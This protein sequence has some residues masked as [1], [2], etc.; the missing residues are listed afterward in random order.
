MNKAVMTLA[1]ILLAVS[2]AAAR[3]QLNEEHIAAPAIS[4]EVWIN[5]PPL[6]LDS[7]RDKVI[8]VDFWDYTCVGC[9]RMLPYLR[10][11][12]RLYGPLGL[13]AIGVQTPE[14]AF[15]K[16]PDLVAQAVKRMGISF[17]VAVDSD[18]RIWKAF[19]NDAMPCEYLIDK[20]GK[21]EYSLCGEED[22]AEF[23]RLIQQLLRQ[24]NPKLDF[25][26]ARFNPRPDPPKT[27]AG[28]VNPTPETYLGYLRADALANTEGYQPLVAASYQPLARLPFDQFD[29]SG[30]WTAMAENVSPAATT[31]GS[32]DSLRFNYRAKSVYLVAGAD[33]D[34]AASVVVTQDGKS[35]VAGSRG[36]DVLIQPDGQTYLP[37]A[38]K[39]IYYVVNSRSFGEHILEFRANGTG[40]GFYAFAFGG[41][42]EPA[43][44]PR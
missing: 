35:L 7:L 33:Q 39:R 40:V 36:A 18:R 38:A 14:F 31:T 43:F 8:L 20:D 30:Q 10:L 19:Q 28:C 2:A 15:A 32:Y 5:S 13:V 3:A 4:A 34:Q 29:L 24:A 17:P 9:I 41:S 11:W 42:C 44:D 27:G 6:A 22:Y 23:E 25:S 21:L 12:N 26:A 37:I 1:V 16:N